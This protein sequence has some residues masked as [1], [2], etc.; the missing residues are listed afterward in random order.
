MKILFVIDDLF[1]GG[2]QRQVVTLASALAKLGNEVEVAVYSERDYYSDI[3]ERN[4]IGIIKLFV[5]E[6]IKR[7]LAF[8]RMIRRRN[9]DI[10]ISFLGVPNF[11]C[12]FA[13]I[14]PKRWK[15]IVNER[16]ADPLIL[17]SFQSRLRRVFHFFS[18]VIVCNS[19][20]N[21][22][23]ILKVN[24]LL[25]VDK[26]KV[27]YNIINFDEWEPDYDYK[28][29]QDGFLHIL[30]AASH[31]HLKNF[32]G[33]LNGL[34]VLH[35]DERKRIRISWYGDSLEPPYNDES[36]EQCNRFIQLHGLWQII[37]TYPA[38]HE[39]CCKMQKADIIGLF[40]FFEGLPNSI[41]EGMALGKPV[42][43]SA[44]SDIPLLIEDGI[45]GKLFDPKDS[46]SIAAALR[47]F[48]EL[49]NNRFGEMGRL[50]R[51]KATKLFDNKRIIEQY[52]ELMK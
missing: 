2:A 25:R 16:S 45:N 14:P 26:I 12:E 4:N 43:A 32:V 48:L 37:H 9:P 6:P 18:N 35:E 31:R 24:P 40:S 52:L 47:Y 30:I 10:V 5:R 42:L 13:A 51:E 29:C 38:T 15:L 50:N 39:I 17:K 21:K 28:Y 1:S 11:I 27:I 49:D 22:E 3:L 41:C 36:I 19:F 46:Q 44:V 8:R 20:A 23:I 34:M 7:L 33:L